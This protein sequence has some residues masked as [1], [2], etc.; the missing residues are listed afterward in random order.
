MMWTTC[1]VPT[2]IARR[3]D[4]AS[5]NLPTPYAK[6]EEAG[7]LLNDGWF[8]A[9]SVIVVTMPDFVARTTLARYAIQSTRPGFGEMMQ[10]QPVLQSKV[11]KTEQ[12]SLLAPATPHALIAPEFDAVY[13]LTSNEDVRLSTMDPLDHFLLHGAAELRNPNAWF[14]TGFYVRT[15]ADVVDADVNPFWHYLAHGRA[16][17]RQPGHKRHA[18]RATLARAKPANARWVGAPPDD[19]PRLTPD[20]LRATIAG[21][22]PGTA[23]FNVS[24]S[25]DRYTHS[26]G[27][28]QILVADEQT[29]FNRQ[30]ETYLVTAQVG[31]GEWR[32]GQLRAKDDR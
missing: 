28:V 9:G 15:N 23:G 18:E 29:A 8:G 12:L 7:G 30:N 27:G 25:H 5:L 1:S 14:D 32:P 3:L 2:L 6:V 10:V 26:V 4:T 13:Y 22:L 24:V 20:S 19:A 16:E 17:G 31:D 21:C 11:V